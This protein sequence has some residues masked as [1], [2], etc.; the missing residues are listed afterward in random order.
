MPYAF[1]DGKEPVE[2]VPGVS[3]ATPEIVVSKDDVEHYGAKAGTVVASTTTHPPNALDLYGPEDLARYRIQ[4]FA[5]P[6]TPAGKVVKDR[7][8]VVDKTGA[9]SVNVS[10]DDAPVPEAVDLLK[11]KI[12][13][14]SLDR[15]EEVDAAMA[16]ADALTRAY[17]QSATVLTRSAPL[18]KSIAKTAGISVEDLFRAASLVEA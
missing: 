16:E 5:E 8:L 2:I 9:I 15:L 4:K 10:Y 14:E 6:E 12:E 18:A 7:K 1:L 11:I 17:W 13:L 3:F